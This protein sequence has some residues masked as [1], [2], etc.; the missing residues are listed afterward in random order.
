MSGNFLEL[1]SGI[2]NKFELEEFLK[3]MK[4]QIF[5]LH[6]IQLTPG[7]VFLQAAEWSW[8][9]EYRIGRE[10]GTAEPNLRPVCTEYAFACLKA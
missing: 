5:F 10:N 7:T 2:Q 9:R 6:W 8:A 1:N 3:I 4:K